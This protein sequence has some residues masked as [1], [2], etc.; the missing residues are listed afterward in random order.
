METPNTL[1]IAATWMMLH[2]M[3]ESRMPRYWFMTEP[4]LSEITIVNRTPSLVKPPDYLGSL[5]SIPI[6]AKAPEEMDNCE[7]ALI[8]KNGRGVGFQHGH[9]YPV[10]MIGNEIMVGDPPD[11]TE[12]I[13]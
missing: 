10:V 6:K 1:N 2:A 3:K 7:I 12:S 11:Q 5:F 13:E 8:N 4:T 9:F